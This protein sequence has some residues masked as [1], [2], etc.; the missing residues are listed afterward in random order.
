MRSTS[1]SSSASS[2]A[3]EP[4]SVNEV[5]PFARSRGSMARSLALVSSLVGIVE[6]FVVDMMQSIESLSAPYR[7]RRNRVNLARCSACTTF[8]GERALAPHNAEAIV[9]D[10]LVA[11]RAANA[12]LVARCGRPR[13]L[14]GAL[15]SN[16]RPQGSPLR[17]PHRGPFTVPPPRAVDQASLGGRGPADPLRRILRWPMPR[18]LGR[19]WLPRHPA[20][21]V[22]G[23]RA[24]RFQPGGLR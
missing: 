21:R 6:T 1:L 24:T 7:Q 17:R 8:L 19:P 16:G 5:T 14:A 2:R 10:A 9:G 18:M 3:T 23:G 11:S 13:A 15:G 22:R 12:A 4:N 20:D